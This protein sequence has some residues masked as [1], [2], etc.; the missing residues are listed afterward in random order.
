M[1][2]RIQSF[3]EFW[4]FYVGEHAK[5]ATRLMHFVGTTAAMACVGAAVI[6]GKPAIALGALVAGYGP[7]WVS[8]FF[9]E[10]NKPASFKYPLW[11]LIAD[12][13]MWSLI[14]TGKMDAE[15]ERIMQER[16]DVAAPKASTNGVDHAK[17]AHS[18]PN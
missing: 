11:S 3:E 14:A 4:P 12:F 2:E 16:A 17:V 13:K 8:H 9:V 10:K 1:S 7:A 18:A 6:K 15:V 5:K